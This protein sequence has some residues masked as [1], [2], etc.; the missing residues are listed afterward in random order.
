M[1]ACRLAVRSVLR[2][3]V[4]SLGAR[5]RGLVAAALWRRPA[6]DASKAPTL[7]RCLGRQVWIMA[8]IYVA[9][10]LIHALR[11]P[12]LDVI[13]GLKCPVRPR[14]YRP[15]SPLPLSCLSRLFR[16]CSAMIRLHPPI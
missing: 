7:T 9:E 13:N 12:D 5:R 2:R 14:R 11:S 15:L 1:G 8:G 16:A 10:F 4:F 6:L 3:G